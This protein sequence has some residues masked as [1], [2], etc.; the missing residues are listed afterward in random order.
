MTT[1]TATIP[2]QQA[3]SRA[4][5]GPLVLGPWA[6]LSLLLSWVGV[7]ATAFYFGIQVA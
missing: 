7:L 2:S 5:R 3:V 6:V 4:R 1:L